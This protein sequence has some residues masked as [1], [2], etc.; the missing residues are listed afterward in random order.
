LMIGLAPGLMAT[1]YRARVSWRDV[2][3]AFL[4]GAVVIVVA[5]GGAI[6]A[7]GSF[8]G[9]LSAVRVHGDYISR[10][11]SF[12]SPERPPLW[13]LFDRFLIKQYDCTPLGI[14]ISMFVAVSIVSAI[15]Q[16]N[17]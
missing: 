1:W 9:Y 7:T 13:R 6:A 8:D 12:R 10:V 11:D 5:F 14:I 2:V 17:R 3:F 15:R 4:I 16:R